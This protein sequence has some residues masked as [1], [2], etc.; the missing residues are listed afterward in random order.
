M[1]R[2][3]VG[4]LLNPDAL[5]QR[6]YFV[7]MTHLIGITVIYRAPMENK[8]YD[9][10]GEWDSYFYPPKAVGCIFDEHPT[11]RTMRKLGWDSER[12]DGMSVIN[13]PYDLKNL[14]A[15]ALFVIPSGIDDAQGRVFRV[16]QM[17]NTMIYPSSVACEIA[18]EYEDSFERSQLDHHNSDLSLL[19]NEEDDR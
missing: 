1:T 7:E 2:K 17:S 11:Q 18:P 9:G 3:D 16:V 5:M 6:R 13:V 10:Y 15:G 12:D 8:H 14:Q 4:I 19:S